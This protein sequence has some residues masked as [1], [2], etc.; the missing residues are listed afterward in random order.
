M[1]RT[2]KEATVKR[3]HYN[4]HDQLRRHLDDFVN[5]YNFGRRLKTLNGLTPYE[6]ICKT[7]TAELKRF[8]L[9]PLNPLNQ[10][11]GPNS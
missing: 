1:N 5:A 6:A 4:T 9:N 2:L 10:M 11:P 7:W 8:T 3:F